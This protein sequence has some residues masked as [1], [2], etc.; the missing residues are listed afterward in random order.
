MNIQ[1]FFLGFKVTELKLPFG[2]SALYELF[3]KHSGC[4]KENE[5]YLRENKTECKMINLNR[6]LENLPKKV[7]CSYCTIPVCQVFI[8]SKKANPQI[9][10][11]P[12]LFLFIFFLSP[13]TKIVFN[14][15]C[16]FLCVFF[17]A[18]LICSPSFNLPLCVFLF[19][20]LN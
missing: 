15:I 5:K 18:H 6:H 12:T 13:Y 16:G 17:S 7:I 3:S 1:F 8:K 19:E 9:D 20:N 10:P 11:K 4:F 2:E 14:F